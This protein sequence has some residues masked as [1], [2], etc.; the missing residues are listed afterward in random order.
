[1][2]WGATLIIFS[3]VVVQVTSHEIKVE[4]HKFSGLP[5]EYSDPIPSMLADL[6]VEL[7]T[8]GGKDKMNISWAIN[9]DSSNTFLTG[10]R[11]SIQGESTYHCRYNPVLAEANHNGSEQIWFHH[12]VKATSG[13]NRILAANLPFALNNHNIYKTVRLQ[14]PQQTTR[15]TP[16]PTTVPIGKQTTTSSVPYKFNYTSIAMAIFGGMAG[17]MILSSC[18]IIYKSYGANIATSLGFKRLPTSSTAPVSVLMVYPAED[19]AFQRAVVALAEFL[20]WH[21]GCNVAVD[22][23]QQ[24][25]IA[26]LGPMRWLAEKA[27]TAHRVLIVCPQP[28]TQPSSHSPL[29]HTSPEPSIPAA[30]HD[31]YPLI[32]NMVASHAKSASD[33]AKFWVV[34]LGEQ[35]DKK[36]SNLAPELRA[37]KTFCLMK[38][39]NKLCRSLY[40]TSQDDKKVSDLI[41]RPVLAFSDK[42][43]VKLREAVE[44]Q[45]GHQPSIFRETEPLKSVVVTV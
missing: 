9:I 10:T 8:V 37:C 32:L 27:K 45:G 7:V 13:F 14:I 33:L 24:R 39:L 36:A 29:K 19:S 31:L 3:F 40:T 43:T 42:C 23:W 35:Q 1:M 21:G 41:F 34:Q 25:K 44:K 5:N 2:M 22:M 30:A 28:S 11:I 38:D 6:R 4:C 16:K 20:Q 26:E 18:Y 17:L 12:L 15:V